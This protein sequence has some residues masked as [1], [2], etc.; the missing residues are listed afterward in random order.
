MNTRKKQVVAGLTAL[1]V[2]FV[3]AVVGFTPGFGDGGA[4]ASGV[5]AEML[6]MAIDP[7]DGNGGG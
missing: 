2:A 6:Q 4:S 5:N 1:A 7:V 3:I